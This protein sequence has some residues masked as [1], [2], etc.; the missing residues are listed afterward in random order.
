MMLGW[1]AAQLRQQ[2]IETTATM[3]RH[4]PRNSG[5]LGDIEPYQH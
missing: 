1:A 4:Q 3:T 2:R 5:I